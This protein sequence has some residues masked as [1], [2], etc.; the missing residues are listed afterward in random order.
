MAFLE[1]DQ[2][3]RIDVA[4]IDTCPHVAPVGCR[5][6]KQERVVEQCKRLEVT[7]LDRQ[8]EQRRIERAA[9]ELFQ[10]VTRLRLA[11]LDA[12][13]RVTALQLGQHAWKHIRCKRRDHTEAQLP[14]QQPAGVT[15]E[16]GKIACGRQHALGA[17][18]DL[19][20]GRGQDHVARAPFDEIGAEILLQLAD[21]HGERR[22]RHRAGLG[23]LAE[24]PMLRERGQI[25]Q[26]S[27]GDH[28][29]KI[30]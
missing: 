13:T 14:G 7:L 8:R 29:D 24:V 1:E 4:W 17:P 6:R 2:S 18:C 20:A 26:L 3:P 11:Q 23:G 27:Q 30:F 16:V 15:R 9:R 5:H 22:L 10:Q 28:A 12:Q 21:L 19:R 25:P